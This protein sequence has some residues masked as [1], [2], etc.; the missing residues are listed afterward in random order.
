[1]SARQAKDLVNIAVITCRSQGVSSKTIRVMGVA[2]S[3]IIRK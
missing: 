2:K 1:M 3:K